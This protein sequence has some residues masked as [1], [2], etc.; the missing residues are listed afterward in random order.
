WDVGN[1]NMPHAPGTYDSSGSGATNVFP[2]SLYY[3]QLQD[4]LA[5]PNTQPRDYWLGVIDG[6]TNIIPRDVVTLDAAWSNAVKAAAAGQPLDPF[7]VVTNNH[8]I[9]FTFNFTPGANEH[10]VGATLA[11]ALRATNSAS[12]DVLY[13]GS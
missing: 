7:N 4:R 11:L 13:L 12:G 5:V 1:T 6:F 3:A 8:W 2:N 9:P 10:I